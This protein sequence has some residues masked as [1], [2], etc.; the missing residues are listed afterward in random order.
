MKMRRIAML[1]VVALILCGCSANG[2]VRMR[3]AT[4]EHYSIGEFTFFV[5]DYMEME[6]SSTY[7]TWISLE[8][9]GVEVNVEIFSGDDVEEEGVDDPEEMVE[10]YADM[11][12]DEGFLV[13][14]EEYKDQVYLIAESDEIVLLLSGYEYNGAYYGIDVILYGEAR[15]EYIEEAKM[16]VTGGECG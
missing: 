5:Y 15:E 2:S 11:Y 14:I 6:E 16:I 4:L 1:L 12:E 13:T 9:D 10:F 8:G 3:N 7:N